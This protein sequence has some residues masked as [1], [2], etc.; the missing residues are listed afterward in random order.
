VQVRHPDTGKERLS[1]FFFLKLNNLSIGWVPLHDA[2]SRGNISV[3]SELLALNAPV[4]PRSNDGETPA[5]LAAA[6]GYPECEEILSALLHFDTLLLDWG[7]LDG[8]LLK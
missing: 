8:F 4:K 5:Q 6:V 2:A 1:I 7:I 3:V